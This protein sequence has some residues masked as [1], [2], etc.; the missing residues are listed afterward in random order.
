MATPLGK[1]YDGHLILDAPVERDVDTDRSII[2][3]P[4]IEPA[5]AEGQDIILDRPIEPRV[6]SATVSTVVGAPF[7]IAQFVMMAAGVVFLT[8]GAVGLARTGVGTWTGATVAVGPFQ[9]T[10]LLAVVFL[11]AGVLAM[12]GVAGRTSSRAMSMILGPLM[13]ASGVVL[14]VQDFAMFGSNDADGMLFL[15]AGA[16]AVIGGILTP[17]RTVSSE[18]TTASL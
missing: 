16:T 14:M 6:E 12:M 17:M 18:R 11:G 1:S 2:L 7:G 3:D 8:I 5:R 15:I 10:M 13:L 4:P 9:M